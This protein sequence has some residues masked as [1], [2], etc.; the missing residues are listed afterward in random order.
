[1]KDSELESKLEKALASVNRITG[2]DGTLVVDN[3]GEIL[4]NNISYKDV[5]LFG[6]MANII[7][8]SSENYSI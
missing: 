8:S 1:M 4:Y 5:D 7:S 6:S 2:V 3:Q